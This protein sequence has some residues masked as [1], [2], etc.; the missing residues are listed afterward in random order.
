MTYGQIAPHPAALMESL[1]AL[2]YSLDAA[3]ADLVDNSIAAGASVV[4]VA[5]DWND[6]DPFA[7]IL[8]D[9]RGMAVKE[10]VEAMRLGGVGPSAARR[11]DDLG[12]YG[13]GLKT[14]SFSQCR[15][16]TVAT[17]QGA[18]V[19][20]ARW[21]L[22]L[23]AASD[24][25]WEL[26]GG[27]APGSAR[28]LELLG[29]LKGSGT[30]VLWEMLHTGSEGSLPRFL[31]AL[32]HLERHLAMVFERFLDG[33]RRRVV[34]KLNGKAIK[35][36]NPFATWHPATM[37]KPVARFRDLSG[38][39]EVRGHVL[40]HRDRFRTAEEHEASGGPEG[41]IAQQGFYVYRVGRLI[42]AGGWLGL[43]GS[44]EW[45][46]DEASQLARIRI[47]IPNITDAAW[48]I[49][50]RK[51]TAR[52]PGTLRDDLIR[53]ALDVRRSARDVYAHRGARVPGDGNATTGGVWRATTSRR[54]P[55]AVKRE[56]PAV[57]VVLDMSSEPALVEAM[58]VAIE[59]SVPVPACVARE[60]PDQAEADE[61]V[62][63]ARVLMRNLIALGLERT[64]ALERVAHTEPFNQVPEI[65][66]QLQND[67]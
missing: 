16:L 49:D 58:L 18:G 37:L 14:A 29:R 62:L 8:D 48:R 25:G 55:Y 44:R 64:A 2:G 28:R 4:E 45:L 61:L 41:W 53:V 20:C 34:I 52:P 47:D 56:H 59:R 32:E 57:Q 39:V 10:L 21:D 11:A 60:L 6:G 24:A 35:A 65:A 50:V 31:Q 26:L 43:G 17:K 67:N 63:A 51:S 9:G 42:V 13:L 46:R 3:I 19:A 22:A 30:L 15:R 33:D 1:R 23:I 38:D 5:F 54:Y 27:P 40:P 7:T 12:R 36:W 66:S